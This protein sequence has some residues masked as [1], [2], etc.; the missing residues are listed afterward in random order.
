[1][2]SVRSRI[3]TLL[4][5]SW[6]A[7][8]F[9][10]SSQEADESSAQ[11]NAV[12]MLLGRLVVSDFDEL[13]K[14]ER[15]KFA[16]TWD[17]PIRKAAHM[18]E[19]VLLGFLVVEAMT[20]RFYTLEKEKNINKYR[21]YAAIAFGIA[22]MYAISDEIHQYFVPGRACMAMDVGIDSVGALIGVGIGLV[23]LQI[24]DTTRKE[25]LVRG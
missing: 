25:K 7:V 2:H 5:I 22:L 10:F 8:I 3:F 21:L 23:H 1:M 15:E 13:P 19:Y 4:A 9:F 12:G 20:D 6:M 17:Y 11:S 18:T 24:K 14:K 16:D